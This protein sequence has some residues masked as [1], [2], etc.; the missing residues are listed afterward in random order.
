[1]T[2]PELAINEPRIVVARQPNRL[3]HIDAIGPHEKVTAGNK[4]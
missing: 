3:V 4:A 1:M 2:K